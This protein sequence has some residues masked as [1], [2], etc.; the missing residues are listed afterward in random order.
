MTIV[1]EAFTVDVFLPLALALAS[2]SSAT[3][4]DAPSCGFTYDYHSDDSW[5]II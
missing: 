4:S 5:G 1:S 2:V 3:V